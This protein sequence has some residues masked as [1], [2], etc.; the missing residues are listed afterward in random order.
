MWRSCFAAAVL[1]TTLVFWHARVACGQTYPERPIRLV[2]SAVGGSTDFAARLVALGLSGNLNQPIIV[3]NRG[4]GLV[5]IEIAA[6]AVPDGYTLFYAGSILWL[7]PLLQD[8]VSYDTLK[9]F[10]PVSLV[11]D[12]PNIV[13]VHPSVAAKSIKELIALA[14]AKPGALN[15]GSGG[16]G[17]SGHLSAE[18]FKAMAG[19]NIVRVAF[20]GS[21][22]ALT[23]LLAGEIQ[24]LIGSSSGTTPHIKGG[25][26]RALAVTS[27]KRSASYP[28][29]PTVAE[30]GLPGYEYGQTSGLFA[31]ARTPAP[32]INR[33]SRETA[34]AVNRPDI[35]EKFAATGAD[36][37][38]STPQEFTA[39][40]KSEIARLGKIIKDAN[41]RAE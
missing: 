36:V 1:T 11:A 16:A 10:A 7:L 6:R 12:S 31:P 37:E 3:D 40:I 32:I 23:S 22:P 13:L 24:M 26:V 29:L 2:T 30:A 21:G 18:L 25:R 5:G 28:D 4:G 17:S 9:D 8:N 41:I 14:K 33:L 34:R 20:K 19:V 39:N 15:Y 38:G 27:A 35:K